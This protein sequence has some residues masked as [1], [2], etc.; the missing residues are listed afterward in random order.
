MWHM[1]DKNKSMI[2]IFLYLLFLIILYVFLGFYYILIHALQNIIVSFTFHQN[3]TD[4]KIINVRNY[5]NFNNSKNIFFFFQYL[6]SV[7]NS[8]S[9]TQVKCIFLV[10]FFCNSKQVGINGVAVIRRRAHNLLSIMIEVYCFE[11]KTDNASALSEAPVIYIQCIIPLLS[12][13]ILF[14]FFKHIFSYN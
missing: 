5:I 9:G 11:H 7:C 14:F 3:I 6:P 8:L 1:I 2:I 13:F 4:R 12:I 10:T